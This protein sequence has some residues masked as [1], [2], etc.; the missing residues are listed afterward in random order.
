MPMTVVVLLTM[1]GPAFGAPRSETT[2]VRQGVVAELT[3]TGCAPSTL[4]KRVPAGAAVKFEPGV[5]VDVGSL[6]TVVVSDTSI[7]NGV[8]RWSVQ[9]TAEECAAHPDDP[10]W[11]WFTEERTWAVT[12]RTTAHAIRA[13]L[14]GGVRSIA[15]FRVAD[16][17]RRTAP[18]IRRARRHFGKPSTLRRRYGVACRATWRS[19]GLT[20]DLLNLGGQDPCRHGYV[21]AGR[22]TGPMAAGWTA[23]VARGPGVVVGTS[24]TYLEAELVGEPGQSSRLWTLGEVWVPYG[25]AGYAPALSA[26]LDRR[27]SVA[28]FEFWVGAGGD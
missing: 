12:V 16:Y 6:E 25:D 20:I 4:T 21:Q 27:G 15:G 5:G 18:T 8:A 2:R 14:R 22:V 19:L 3:G 9:P 10:D 11:R 1:C 28:G 26:R 24:D 23:I 13:G 17:T 7:E